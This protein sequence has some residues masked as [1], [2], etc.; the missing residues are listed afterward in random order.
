MKYVK[1]FEN[2]IEGKRR[3]DVL[4]IIIE[5]NSLKMKKLLDKNKININDRIYK[6]NGII[7]GVSYDIKRTLD[8]I[9]DIDNANW[10]LL[11]IASYIGKIDIIETLIE[12]GDEEYINENYKGLTALML[13]SMNNKI[14]A[15]ETL[16][17]LGSNIYLT[18]DK[19]Q[20][21]LDISTKEFRKEIIDTI[22]DENVIRFITAK[23]FNI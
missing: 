2:I 22:D 9:P 17:K 7:F 11:M 4:D 8:I 15:V 3:N 5:D 12:F 18:N 16:I 14:L 23:K 19:G 13:A 1:T 6:L 21:F 10:T 20:D